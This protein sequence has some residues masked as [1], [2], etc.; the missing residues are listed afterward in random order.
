MVLAVLMAF[1]LTTVIL[2][3]VPMTFVL[4]FSMVRM[5]IPA[6]LVPHSRPFLPLRCALT[7]LSIGV[8]ASPLSHVLV[9]LTASATRTLVII[10]RQHRV[11]ACQNDTCQYCRYTFTHDRSLLSV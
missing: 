2:A 6:I 4:A 5:V 8:L 11:A 9:R 7:P 1:M 3:A 10:A